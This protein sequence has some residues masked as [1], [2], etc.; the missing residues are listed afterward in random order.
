[1][2]NNIIFRM[3]IRLAPYT[4]GVYLIHDNSL[5]RNMLWYGL[6][7]QQ[8]FEK[9]YFIP[10][11]IG[12]AIVVFLSCVVIDRLREM[13]WGYF[14]INRRLENLGVYIDNRVNF[15]ISSDKSRY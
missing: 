14:K 11:W 13:L 10:L 5:V 12:V 3:I 15:F 9:L 4:F 2:P 6:N 1:M 8:Y 7:W